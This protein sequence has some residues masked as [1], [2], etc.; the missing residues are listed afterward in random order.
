MAT[1]DSLTIEL[2]KDD[3]VL[4]RVIYNGDGP[5]NF[6]DAYIIG[7]MVA[8]NI[9]IIM[10]STTKTAIDKKGGQI[11]IQIL[12]EGGQIRIEFLIN[13]K[14]KPQILELAQAKANKQ[15][16]WFYRIGVSGN[17]KD[18]GE[19][20]TQYFN[21]NTVL[22]NNNILSPFLKELYQ[23]VG[24][25]KFIQIVTPDL[26]KNLKEQNGKKFT[27]L[28][29]ALGSVMFNLNG[30][31]ETFELDETLSPEAK[32]QIRELL[33][34]YNLKKLLYIVNID[35]INRDRFFMALCLF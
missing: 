8:N 9:P 5:N 33:K 19:P 18:E 34:K 11:G 12:I 27:Q 1:Q 28:E 31:V 20:H 25:E 23:I 32:G 22:I 30:F 6:I 17:K 2:P 14:I 29:G 4:I 35:H 15:E 10:V 24:R 16:S 26:I 13:G 3:Q 21:T 7:W